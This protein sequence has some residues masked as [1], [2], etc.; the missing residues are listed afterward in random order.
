MPIHRVLA[1][2]SLGVF[3]LSVDLQV[4]NNPVQSALDSLFVFAILAGIA[5]AQE[6]GFPL[7]GWAW[8]R[9]GMIYSEA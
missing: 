8:G 6:L 9:W 7:E 3:F 5:R 4:G 1:Y 2:E